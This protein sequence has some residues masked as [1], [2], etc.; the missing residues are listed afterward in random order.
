MR[1][2]G[3]AHSDPGRVR[4][5][6]QD[7]YGFSVRTG[8]YLVADGMGGHAGGKRASEEASWAVT[9]AVATGVKRSTNGAGRLKAAIEKA[10]EHVWNLAQSDP[11]LHGMGTTVAAVLFESA[12]AHV[13]NVG[14]SRVYHVRDGAIM[15]LTRDHSYLADLTGQGVEVTDAHLRERYDRMLTRAVGVAPTV[16]V[17]VVTV[18]VQS[19]DNF[20][21]CSDGIHRMVTPAE[22][23]AMVAAG[24]ND[25]DALC[26]AIV[27][28]ANDGG[29]PDNST[30]IVLRI[31]PEG[32]QEAGGNQSGSA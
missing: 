4:L 23:L 5:E 20:I 3:A 8:L 14:D 22:M 19:E 16:E 12:V 11:A 29:G 2:A 32:P 28:R 17:D 6:N 1:L 30:V 27:R 18:G 15:A 24:G 25:L 9:D 13:A 10:N 26:A 31:L 7:S 21:L